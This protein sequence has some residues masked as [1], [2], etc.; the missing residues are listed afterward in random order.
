MESIL[1]SACPYCGGTDIGIGYQLG[2][3]QLYERTTPRGNAAVWST[4][5]AKTAVPFSAPAR[6]GPSF[7]ILSTRRESW[8]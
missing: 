4:F 8:S 1:P 5:C 3:G 7:F 6:K 2:A